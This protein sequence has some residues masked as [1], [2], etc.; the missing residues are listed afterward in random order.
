MAG[1]FSQVNF[2]LKF[3]AKLSKKGAKKFGDKN[4]CGLC[5]FRLDIPICLTVLIPGGYA[6]ALKE[7]AVIMSSEKLSRSLR[8]IAHEIIERNSGTDNLVLIG[9]RSRGVPLATRLANHISQIEGQ[10]VP[11]GILDITLHRDDIDAFQEGKGTESKSRIP[12]SVEGRRVVLVDDVLYTGRTV[13]AALDALLDYGRPSEVQLAVV[14]DRGH[15]EIPIR[16]DYVGKNVP[17]SRAEVISVKVTE[18]DGQDRVT[19]E[20]RVPD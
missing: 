13:R 19:I 7:K 18:I 17:T 16:A 5:H 14:I 9:I 20:E 4:N 1:C 6:M 10:A 8:R 15:R 11:V 2:P 12:F 3:R